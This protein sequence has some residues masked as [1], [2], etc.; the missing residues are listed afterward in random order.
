MDLIAT[1][2]IFHNLIFYLKSLV[3]KHMLL[4]EMSIEILK[5]EKASN[6]QGGS[7]SVKRYISSLE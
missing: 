5:G 3:A 6:T 4:V 2:V 7:Y 1:R